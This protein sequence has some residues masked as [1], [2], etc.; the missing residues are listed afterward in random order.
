MIL[1]DRSLR[2]VT[3]LPL[4]ELWDEAGNPI[5]AHRGPQLNAGVIRR[6]L[7][8]DEPA[9]VVAAVGRPLTWVSTSDRY[10]FWKEELGVRLVEA[11]SA[12]LEDFPGH[13]AYLTTQWQTSSRTIVLCEKWQ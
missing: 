2:V 10:L 7:R 3:N 5:Q 6:L 1:L 9:F 11:E 8:G 13:Y 12:Y 4:D